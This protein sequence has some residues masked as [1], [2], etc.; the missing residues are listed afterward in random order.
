MLPG[1]VSPQHPLRVD[2]AN[3][4]VI[5][6]AEVNQQHF[7]E[8]S[9]HGVGSAAGTR[10]EEFLLRSPANQLDFH[11]KLLEIGLTPGNNLTLTSPKTDV[12]QGDLLDVD[13]T[14]VGAPRW[15]ALSEV[16]QDTAGEKRGVEVRFGGNRSA[17]A[18]KKTGCMTCLYSCPVGITS[19]T[20]Y[21]VQDRDNGLAQ[22]TLN[23]AVLPQGTTW[24]AIRYK[25]RVVAQ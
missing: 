23:E 4:Q 1:G 19:N 12:V 24:V 20:Q 14:W 10:R 15:Y 5:I 22:Y 2:P 16:L 8:P 9:Q 11:D 17:S 6:A 21:T 7:T 18:D 13:V 25:K 3:Q